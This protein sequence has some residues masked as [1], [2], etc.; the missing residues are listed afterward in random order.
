MLVTS[1][2]YVPYQQLEAIRTWAIPNNV[3]IE[4]VGFPAEWNDT[5]QQG[6]MMAANYLQEIRSTIQAANRYLDSVN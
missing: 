3:Y 4:T 2:I 5:K 1:Q 6:M